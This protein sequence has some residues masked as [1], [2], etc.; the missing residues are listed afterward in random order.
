VSRLGIGAGYGAPAAACEKAFHEF[1][2]NYFYY[3]L[4]RRG[5]MRRALHN[6][7]P[8]HRDDLVIAVQTYDHFGIAA[9][10]FVER[11]L[12]TL[13][14][15]VADVLILGWFNHGPPKRVIDAALK[16]KD[17]GKIRFIAM[18]GHR[19]VLFAEHAQDPNSP[20]D[21][22]M[23]RY[24]AAHPGAEHDVFPYLP[25]SNR[26]GVYTYTT[27]SWGELLDSRKMPEG[28]SPMT[29]TECYRF[30]LANPNVDMCLCGPRS[31]EEMDAALQTLDSPPATDDEMVRWRRIGAHVYPKGVSAAA[32]AG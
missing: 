13:R 8:Q 9:G 22:F 29:S 19:R 6:L 30:A 32:A 20:I 25:E 4:P 18:S 7:A 10:H 12:R 14:I 1:G 17:Q 15:D 27:T 24:N 3:S 16:L 31:A 23:I 11:T 2:V 21:I 28:E 26:P 5:G